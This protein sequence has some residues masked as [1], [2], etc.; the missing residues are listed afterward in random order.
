VPYFLMIP[1]NLIAII[2]FLSV[3]KLL[4]WSFSLLV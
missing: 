2:V 1:G 4:A 3:L